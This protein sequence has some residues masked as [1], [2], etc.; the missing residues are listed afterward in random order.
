MGV[1]MLSDNAKVDMIVGGLL[2][3]D[4]F[5]VVDLFVNNHTPVQGDDTSAFTLASYAGYGSETW[6]P[7]TPG[8]SGGDKAVVTPFS[9]T[10]TGP[11]SGGSDSIYGYTVRYTRVDGT[12]HTLMSALFPSAPI[13]LANSSQSITVNLAFDDYDVNNP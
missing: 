3:H 5:W 8:I 7:G 2:G 4:S 9:G 10:F 1:A 12:H 6:S 13:V 11:T